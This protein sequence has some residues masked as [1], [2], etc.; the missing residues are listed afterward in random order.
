[1]IYEA[2]ATFNSL[3]LLSETLITDTTWLK[4]SQ[5]VAGFQPMRYTIYP[6]GV[7][8]S[9]TGPV[10]MINYSAFDLQFGSVCWQVDRYLQQI[11][12]GAI[13]AGPHTHTVWG[14]L[15]I[16]DTRASMFGAMMFRS[17]LIN[18]MDI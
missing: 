5:L 3:P 11:S 12:L 13:K 16:Y 9:S 7:D 14:A 2:I 4:S 8:E 1:M 17:C 10:K 18:N 6:N 15:P